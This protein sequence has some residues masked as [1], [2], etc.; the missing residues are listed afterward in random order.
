MNSKQYKLNK[1]VLSVIDSCYTDGHLIGAKGFAH[2][3]ADRIARRC[4][5]SIIRKEYY[6][7][8]IVLKRKQI[9]EN[10]MNGE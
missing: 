5:D 4:F 6:N 3:V 2:L 1:K 7:G 10:L 9:Q 8:L